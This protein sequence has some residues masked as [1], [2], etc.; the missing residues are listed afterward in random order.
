LDT[1]QEANLTTAIGPLA[2]LP[3]EFEPTKLQEVQRECPAII[4]PAFGDPNRRAMCWDIAVMWRGGALCHFLLFSSCL[5]VNVFATATSSQW[6]HETK[7]GICEHLFRSSQRESARHSQEDPLVIWLGRP[8]MAIHVEGKYG[9]IP[10]PSVWVSFVN[11]LYITKCPERYNRAESDDTTSSYSSRVT[12]FLTKWFV[13]NPQYQQRDLYLAGDE[14]DHTGG[15]NLL[16]LAMKWKE[17]TIKNEFHLRGLLLGNPSHVSVI[18]RHFGHRSFETLNNLT[19]WSMNRV[20]QI[21][22]CN[23]HF[24]QVDFVMNDFQFH[25]TPLVHSSTSS[26]IPS[27]EGMHE[28]EL[29]TISS[30]GHCFS[31]PE[32]WGT[33]WQLSSSSSQSLYDSVYPTL[34]HADT[35][36]SPVYPP[37]FPPL[38]TAQTTT[39]SQLSFLLSDPSFTVIMYSSLYKSSQAICSF[40]IG[41]YPAD[42]VAY[43]HPLPP[44]P[45]SP[46]TGLASTTPEFPTA[47][48]A[49]AG[50]RLLLSQR[51]DEFNEATLLPYESAWTTSA[52][53]KGRRESEPKGVIQDGIHSGRGGGGGFVWIQLDHRYAPILAKQEGSKS[54]RTSKDYEELLHRVT[55]VDL[56]AHLLG[57]HRDQDSASSS[58]SSQ[59][60]I[61]DYTDLFL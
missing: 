51:I 38:T 27:V 32:E 20:Q 16:L 47:T 46:D 19:S 31:S 15:K 29:S 3:I 26:S 18:S 1:I 57:K 30:Y 6:Q 2:Q 54:K 13:F 50:G 10:M 14:D 28:Y 4:W 5:C 52:S 21:I 59:H 8:S 37:C 44:V 23:S 61:L 39:Q 48:A 9:P 58:S 49:E 35:T 55:A 11:V 17:E 53:S 12:K 56:L 41:I 42:G 25:Y 22:T 40:Y 24:S 33:D 60:L 36:S 7:L 43:R 34:S 45:S